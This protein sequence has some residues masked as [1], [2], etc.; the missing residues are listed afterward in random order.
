MPVPWPRRLPA[1]TPPSQGGEGG[2]T[3]LGATRSPYRSG[4][5]GA[6]P[7][8][9]RPAVPARY[10]GLRFHCGRAGARPSLI[11]SDAVV[12]LPGPQFGSE[13]DDLAM[14]R[15]ANWHSDQTESL[16][17]V[18]SNPTRATG[19]RPRPR[20][21]GVPWSNGD[22]TSLTKRKR[23]F[24]SLRDDWIDR[25]SG[26]WSAGVPG[27]FLSCKEGDRVRLSGGP[28]CDGMGTMVRGCD[29]GMPP[30]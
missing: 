14:A 11:N 29:G 24:D 18:G 23:G 4:V 1:R 8:L 26:R 15:Y 9:I 16:M 10:R 19:R 12:R 13:R 22:D 20:E 27:A 25:G 30:R 21:C 7:A 28:C 17:S 2:S 5:A 3:P 6:P